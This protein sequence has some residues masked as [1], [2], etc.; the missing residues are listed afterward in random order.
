LQKIMGPEEFL[1]WFKKLAKHDQNPLYLT[2]MKSSSKLG[3]GIRDTKLNRD[4]SSN[5]GEVADKIRER[6][7]ARLVRSYQ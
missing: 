4:A 1:H 3:I 6:A 5:W 7:K 2:E